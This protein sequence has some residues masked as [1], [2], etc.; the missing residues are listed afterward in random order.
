[1]F[2]TGLNVNNL[3][4]HGR[5]VPTFALNVEGVAPL[6]VVK[7]LSLKNIGAKSGNYYAVNVMDR[8]GISANVAVRLGLVHYLSDIDVDRVV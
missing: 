4:A 8:L 6:S 5:R 1:M 2:N 3:S 7:Q